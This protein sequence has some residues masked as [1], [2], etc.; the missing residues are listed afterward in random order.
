MT[1][2][3]TEITT[4]AAQVRDH[5]VFPDAGARVAELL[6]SRLP[7]YAGLTADRLAATVT[8]DM[9][10]GQPDPHLRLKYR[11]DVVPAAL[12]VVREPGEAARNRHGIAKVE[13]LPAN[14]GLLDIRALYRPD[15]SG[16]AA[17]AAMNLV[18]DTAALIVDLRAN[19]GGDPAMVALLCGYLF[20]DAVHLNDI[21]DRLRGE[22][23]QYWTPP[24]LPGPRF[25]GTKPVYVLTSGETFSGAEEFAYNLQQL[26]RATLVGETT[27]GGAHPSTHWRIADHLVSSVPT[28]RAVNPVSGTNWERVGVRPDV[29]VTAADAF[30]TAYRLATAA[31]R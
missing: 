16:A 10:A 9:Q 29:E 7:G 22:V 27:R 30:E 24:V 19:R 6:L 13:L 18:A 28:A 25:G 21:H 20:D 23:R 2:W 8:E 14:I 11:A 3:T 1:D 17:T 15:E 31:V 26:R 12:E 5:Y 4:L